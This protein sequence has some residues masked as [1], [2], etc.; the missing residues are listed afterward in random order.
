VVTTTVPVER[1]LPLWEES[2]MF[3]LSRLKE[4]GVRLSERRF[5]VGEVI[6]TRKEIRSAVRVRSSALL[7][8]CKSCKKIKTSVFVS[9]ALSAVRKQ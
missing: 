5:E 9:G 1:R 3:A 4:A 2:A 7:F 8:T 6:Y